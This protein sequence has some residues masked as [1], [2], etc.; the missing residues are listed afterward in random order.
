VRSNQLCCKR[1]NVSRAERRPE[2]GGCRF[3]MPDCALL[4]D[5]EARTF[6]QT[7]GAA[8]LATLWPMDRHAGCSA[9][10]SSKLNSIHGPEAT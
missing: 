9:K 8:I 2:N 4:G 7:I 6:R 1:L 10:L 3:R 5:A